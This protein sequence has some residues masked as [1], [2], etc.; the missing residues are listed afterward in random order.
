MDLIAK[1]K[2]IIRKDS[3]DDAFD[4]IR[5]IVKNIKNCSNCRFYYHPKGECLFEQG[6]IPCDW[7]KR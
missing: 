7:K 2:T 4:T 1:I 5:D 3:V 6:Y